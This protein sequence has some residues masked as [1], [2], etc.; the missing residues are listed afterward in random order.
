MLNELGDEGSGSLDDL[1]H[2]FERTQPRPKEVDLQQIICKQNANVTRKNR[3][4]W[5]QDFVTI[6]RRVWTMSL[7]AATLVAI[8]SAACLVAV[9]LFSKDGTAFAQVKEQIE[10]IRTVE[11]IET[12]FAGDDLNSIPAG[13]KLG[14]TL[15]E[16]IAQL[17]NNLKSAEPA[18]VKDFEF[19]LQVLRSLRMQNSRVLYVR[20]VRVKG[21]EL[22]RTDQ[23]FPH[24]RYHFIRSAVTGLHVSFDHIA[25]K[26]VVLS[27]QVIIHKSGKKEETEIRKIPSTVDFF[28]RFRTLTSDATEQLP[29]RILDGKEVLG[30]R[31]SEE[32]SGRTWTRTYWVQPDSK[33]PVE[34]WTEIRNGEIIEQRWVMNRFVFDRDMNDS[35]FSTE[36][37]E[38]YTSEE[39]EI[40]G[41]SRD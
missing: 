30:F 32:H 22:E 24:G 1:R 29:A 41:L 6:N 3:P 26:K 33:L 9:Q 12:S 17:E 28:S 34:M 13:A 38:A 16:A 23:V 11:Y 20:R 5:D 21:K 19:E 15:E 31:S 4:M 40:L 14:P 7:R 35:L 39:G 37:P 8:A 27:K 36:T 18:A 2:L 25:K 10:R